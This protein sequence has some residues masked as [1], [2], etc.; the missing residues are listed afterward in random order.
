MNRAYTVFEIDQLRQVVEAIWL[1]GNPSPGGRSGPFVSRVYGENEKSVAV[2]EMV[3]THMLAGHTADDI[4]K[5]YEAS[6]RAKV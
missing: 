5:A 3:R 4:R 6:G 1:Y 2:E